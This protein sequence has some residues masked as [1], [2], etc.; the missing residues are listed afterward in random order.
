MEHA[1]RKHCKVNG[2]DD[3]VFFKT[4]S[5]KLESIIKKLGENWEQMVLALGELRT[6]VL[7][8][9]GDDADGKGPFHDLSVGMIAF[10]ASATMLAPP[11]MK[12]LWLAA[13]G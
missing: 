10:G 12:R 2:E 1:I 8:G 11:S 13:T 7:K 5:E 9:R 3:P 4:M 6:E